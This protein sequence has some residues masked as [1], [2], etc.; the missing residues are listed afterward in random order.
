MMHKLVQA[1]TKLTAWPLQTVIFRTKVYYENPAV[2]KKRIK[3]A[4]IIVSNHTSVFDFALMMFTFFGRTLRCLVAELIFEKPVLG[5]YI[6]GLGGVRVDRNTHNFSFM[7]EAE[8]IL[9]DGGVVEI[10]PESRIPNPGEA[11]PL[12]FKP[13]AA[14]LALS[15]GVKVIPV[16]TNGA[17]FTRARTRMIIGTPIDPMEYC[18]ETLTDKENIERLNAVFRE[19]ILSLEAQLIEK[20]A[21]Q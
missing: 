6:R 13:S 7:T 15:T 18:D 8:Q 19:R 12:P 4:A 20:S 3:G 10:Y 2:Q 16:Y 5:K 1:F 11:R 9:R 17:Y 14:Y 21:K